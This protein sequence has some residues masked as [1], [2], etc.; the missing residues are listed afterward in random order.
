MREKRQID[1]NDLA[2]AMHAYAYTVYCNLFLQLLFIFYKKRNYKTRA[3][4][5]R[6]KKTR[7][8]KVE[9]DDEKKSATAERK[10]N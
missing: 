8:K 2:N 10:G 3:S 7:V 5:E 4:D 9:K 6:G 1:P